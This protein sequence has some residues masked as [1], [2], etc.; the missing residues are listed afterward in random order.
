MA[1]LAGADLGARGRDQEVSAETGFHVLGK[2]SPMC[3]ITLQRLLQ[4]DPWG[5][6]TLHQH[7]VIFA[8]GSRYYLHLERL[9][10]C[11]LYGFV[12]ILY[13][14]WPCILLLV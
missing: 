6:Q 7:L 8:G 5:P 9:Q 11:S 10:A 13:V 1:R 14:F 4:L 3:L 2:G 12:L